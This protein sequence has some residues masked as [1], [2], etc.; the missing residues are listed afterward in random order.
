VFAEVFRTVHSS[1]FVV[2]TSDGMTDDLAIMNASTAAVVTPIFSAVQPT[3]VC[4]PAFRPVEVTIDAIALTPCHCAAVAS[5]LTLERPAASSLF[6]VSVTH[7]ALLASTDA[8]LPASKIRA[9]ISGGPVHLGSG[10][11][12]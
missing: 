12:G 6:V 4:N 8:G 3:S 10:I 5:V 11:F 2:D 7:T 9:M 1:R